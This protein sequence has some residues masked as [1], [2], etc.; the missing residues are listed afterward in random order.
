MNSTKRA[1]VYKALA[2]QVIDGLENNEVPWRKTWNSKGTGK[3]YNIMSG[4]KYSGFN[5]F[6]LGFAMAINGYTS[7]GFITFKAASELGANVK[8]GSRG[9]KVVFWKEESPEDFADR[10]IKWDKEGREGS[11]PYPYS[12]PF[13]STVFNLDAIEFDPE[14]PLPAAVLRNMAKNTP[15]SE[16]VESFNAIESAEEIVS[17]YLAQNPALKFSNKGGDRACYSPSSDAVM[18][19]APE[20][21]ESPDNYYQVTFHE[22]GHSTGHKSRTG[23]LSEDRSE[24]APFGSADYSKEELVAELTSLFVSSEAR[25]ELTI[26]NSTAYIKNWLT[27]LKNDPS[28]VINAAGKA[29]KAADYILR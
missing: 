22:L 3:L 16:E 8:K 29:Q 24:L 12:D 26:E 27:V 1:A 11:E 14:R 21:F 15:T 17:H 13:Y 23:R 2:Q 5:K 4:W 6:N 20:D 9:I 19:P 7:N 18:M 25:I 28:M 10:W